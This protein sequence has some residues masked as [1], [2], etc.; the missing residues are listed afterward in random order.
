METNKKLRRLSDKSV[1]GGVAAGVAEYFGTDVAL[2]RVIFVLL[3]I[4]GKGFPIV[5]VY[6]VLWAALPKEYAG[7]TTPELYNA[8]ETQPSDTKTKNMKWGGYALLIVG[9][10]LL[11]D[12]LDIVFWPNFDQ[13]FWPIAF[14]VGGLYLIVGRKKSDDN[15]PL[16]PNTEEQI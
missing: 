14:I 7:F 16:P 1:I 11:V 10:F 12:E 6:V 15:Q 5:L 9:A 8:A 3:L 2:V 4:F 13:Y